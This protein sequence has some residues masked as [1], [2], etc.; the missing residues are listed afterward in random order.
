MKKAKKV[1]KEMTELE[2]VFECPSCGGHMSLDSTFLDQVSSTVHCPY[3]KEPME[4]VSEYKSELTN[5]ISVIVKNNGIV[6]S[7]RTFTDSTEA[8]EVF[9][10]EAEKV[11]DK[12]CPVDEDIHLGNGCYENKCGDEIL[13]VWSM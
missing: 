9:L 3:C 2:G 4:I 13:L 11:A 6:N 12:F 7:I 8:E 1:S 10:F 5:V